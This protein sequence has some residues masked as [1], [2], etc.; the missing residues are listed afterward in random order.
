MAPETGRWVDL[1]VDLMLGKV[2]PSVGQRSCRR[3]LIFIAWAQLFLVG[4]TVRAE[5]FLM[6]HSA[7]IFLLRSREFVSR[8]KIRGM[9]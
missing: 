9:V 5:R 1:A 7:D 3:I 6:A 8:N 2:I 4:M